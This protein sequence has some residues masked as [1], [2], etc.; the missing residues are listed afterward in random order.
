MA[1]QEETRKRIEAAAQ[2]G[3]QLCMKAGESQAFYDRFWQGLLSHTDIL[4][5]FV[6]YTE[7]QE[8]RCKAKVQGVTVTDI[9]VWQIDHFKAA[10]DRD[11]EDTRSN[12]DKMVLYAFDTMIQMAEDPQPYLQKMGSE[13]GTDYVGKYH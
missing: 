1:M 9:L 5:E 7:H 11:C 4:A 6:Y 8:F 10:L 13:T 2:F 12:R 3:A